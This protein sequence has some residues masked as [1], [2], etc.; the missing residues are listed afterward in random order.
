MLTMIELEI[1]KSE[2]M[3]TKDNRKNNYIWF[4]C[5]AIVI[6]VIVAMLIYY[7]LFNKDETHIS[8][9]I[10]STKTASIECTAGKIEDEFFAEENAD[11]VK[12]TIKMMFVSD[13]FDRLFYNYEGKYGSDAA[14]E[15]ANA[16]LHGRYNK[17]MASK[18]VDPDSLDPSFSNSGNTVKIVLNADSNDLSNANVNL[19]FLSMDE[20]QHIRSYK[21]NDW[22]KLYKGKGFTCEKHD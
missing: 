22:M 6:I 9:G 17:Y 16:V 15:T 11:S 8:Q 21:I 4:G 13:K 1:V 10:D 14:A 19:F 7:F 18:S 20:F 3:M 5:I 12:N 2:V